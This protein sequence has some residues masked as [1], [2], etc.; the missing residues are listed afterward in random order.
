[1]TTTQRS[2]SM[3]SVFKRYASYNHD[4]LQFFHH[5]QRLV[6]DP[7]YE[8]LKAD[9]R[10]TQSTP[11]LSF[12]V[13]MLKHAASMYTSDVF[14]LFQRELSKAHDCNLKKFGESGTVIEY[15]ISPYGKDDQHYLMDYYVHDMHLKFFA[16]TTLHIEKV[17]KECKIREYRYLCMDKLDRRS[18]G[19]DGKTIQREAYNIA[20]D[21]LKKIAEEVDAS[22][23]GESNDGTSN[24]N[25]N[26][27]LENEATL[28]K[29]IEKRVKRVES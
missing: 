29:G 19:I 16:I 13:E 21:C 6:D 5:F 15:D 3:N 28:V 20:L 18:K 23:A 1:M 17:D 4:L 8:E 14:V 10:A 25:N 22:L 7:R 26:A 2:E 24:A 11:S 27:S 9:F 12:P